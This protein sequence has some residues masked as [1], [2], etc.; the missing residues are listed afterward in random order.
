MSIILKPSQR[1]TDGL[2]RAL[3][4]AAGSAG[5]SR[6]DA[7]L[8]WRRHRTLCIVELDK[9]VE[10]GHAQSVLDQMA[11]EFNKKALLARLTNAADRGLYLGWGLKRVR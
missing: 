1:A 6:D 5:M 9:C 8:R 10:S 4:D 3:G 7:V 11:E 2:E